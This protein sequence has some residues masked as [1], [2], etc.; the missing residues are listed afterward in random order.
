MGY[1]MSHILS[2]KYNIGSIPCGY[3]GRNGERPQTR[4]LFTRS[5]HSFK[6]YES[7][8]H[9]GGPSFRSSQLGVFTYTQSHCYPCIFPEPHSKVHNI[10]KIHTTH[11]ISHDVTR[12]VHVPCFLP[13]L[14]LMLPVSSLVF[15]FPI[16]FGFYTPK[17]SPI[18]FGFEN[19]G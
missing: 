17:G 14:F 4:H 3:P 13:F 18:Y 1:V 6:T 11:T 10:N 8:E 7:D 9:V 16:Q 5:F 19:W 2:A 15:T 12:R